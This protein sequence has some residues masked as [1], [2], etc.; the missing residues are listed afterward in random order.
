MDDPEE[1][2]KDELGDADELVVADGE[3]ELAVMLVEPKIVG[4]DG[5]L[6]MLESEELDSCCFCKGTVGGVS[7]TGQF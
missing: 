6:S 2:L 5:P 3:D 7:N 4:E 1:E